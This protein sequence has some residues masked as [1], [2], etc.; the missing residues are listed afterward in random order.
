MSGAGSAGN[1]GSR[2]VRSGSFGELGGQG[3]LGGGPSSGQVGGGHGRDEGG[4]VGG[5]GREELRGT[6]GVSHVG[7]GPK[8]Y[9]RPDERIEEE[10]NERLE[11]DPEIDATDIEVTVKDGEV[12]LS[13]TVESRR[14]KR[15]A[16]DLV[17]DVYGVKD[18]Q[19]RLR[20]SA[21]Q[22]GSPSASQ[23]A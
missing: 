16:E 14:V 15:L 19:N 6:P 23:G 9:R 2:P 18:V 11:R 3:F 21:S 5:R 8:N 13:G 4:R 7:R 20:M 22:G 12:T 17:D 1:W 10:I